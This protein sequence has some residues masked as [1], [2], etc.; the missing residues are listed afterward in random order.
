MCG[1]VGEICFK[2]KPVDMAY[3][4][5]ELLKGIQHRGHESAGMSILM[6]SGRI[7]TK[8]AEG[9]VIEAIP[10]F[11]VIKRKGLAGIGQVR[12]STTGTGSSQK[13]RKRAEKADPFL[14]DEEIS[15]PS[16]INSQP[17]Y[18]D[19]ENKGRVGLNHNGNLT[20]AQK[21]RKE[22]EKKGMKFE[23]ESDTEVILRLICYYARNPKLPM[24]KAIRK[25]MNKMKGAY[26]CI[27]ISKNGL[28]AFRDPH[29]FRPLKIAKTKDSWIFASEPCA[30][31]NREAKPPK[32]R[33]HNVLSGEIVEVKIGS[34]ELK[35]YLPKT[36]S[37]R[38]FCIF[39]DV[40]LQVIHNQKV[41]SSRFGFGERMF[42]KYSFAGI[43]I[44]IMNSGEGAALGY[45]FAQV[46]KF[47]GKA[48]YYPALYR[49]PKVGRTFL[50]PKQADRIAK[51]K[52]KYFNLFKVLGPMIHELAKTEKEI[53]LIMIDDSLIRSN[54]S[55]TLIKMIRLIL[56]KLFP[57]LYRRIKI[58]WL[59]SSPPYTHP[60]YF[61][62]DT[63]EQEQLIAAN[64]NQDEIKR[65]IGADYLGYLPVKDMKEV[66][67]KVH[68][69][70]TTD[71]CAACFT[72][73][74]PINIDPKQDKMSLAANSA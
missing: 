17:F 53:W 47:H 36:K 12:Y 62:I 14:E 45:H 5:R 51:N 67:A 10:H 16:L 73:K 26:S 41:A 42:L 57:K 1:I 25:A 58:A 13:Q 6:A 9:E 39:E 64:K 54:V 32:D 44:P 70:K 38:A 11:W 49:N 22:L 3:R 43:V 52:R 69:L 15:L 20:N 40:Y 46:K 50:E 7:K 18:Y 19:S 4:I 74:Y 61:G 72:G 21:L 35:S 33:V 28:W 8:K 37:K 63:Y 34:R 23:T 71:F 59:L 65:S 2:S 30:W 27:L 31:H 29:G 66:A 60:C 24:H 56:K 48:F 55:K 68:D